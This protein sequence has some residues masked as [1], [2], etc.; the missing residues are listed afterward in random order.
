MFK[1]HSHGVERE[2]DL[3][4]IVLRW[5]KTD[6][7]LHQSEYK[8]ISLHHII[9]INTLIESSVIARLWYWARNTPEKTPFVQYHETDTFHSK[10]C[11]KCTFTCSVRN[12]NNWQFTLNCSID[13]SFLNQ[14][15]ILFQN[16]ELTKWV[17]W[18]L[19]QMVE[20]RF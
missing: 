1:Y 6:R 18:Y 16:G 15:N 12:F 7:N 17:Y 3:L 4:R 2:K 5:S 14:F 9:Y 8:Y 10:I 13:H 20:I 11:A 19:S